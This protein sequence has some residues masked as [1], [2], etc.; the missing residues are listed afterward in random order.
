[1]KNKILTL[2]TTICLLALLLTSCASSA[3]TATSWGGAAVTDSA[4][5]YAD[6]TQVY[7]LKIDNGNTIWG[8]YPEKAVATR[9]FL[10]APVVIG[11]QVLFGDYSGLLTSLNTS[12]GKENWQFS[13]ATG[14]YIDSPLVVG[15]TIVAPNAD[16]NLYALDLNGN[17]LWTFSSEHSFWA[18][19][20]SDGETVFAPCMDHYLYAIDL[21]TGAEKWKVD[22]KA[23]LVGRVTLADGI[24]YLGSLDSDVFAVKSENGSILWEQKV[25]GGVWSAPTLVDDQLFFGDQAGNIN[26]LNVSNGSIAQTIATESAILGSGAILTEGIAF[27]N[28]NGDLILIGLDG[29]KKWTRSINGSIYSN[30][31]LYGNTLVVL[32]NKGEKPL[33][34]FDTDGNEN[35]YFTTK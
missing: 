26:I 3:S 32:A 14:K 29:E 10:A 15:D 21:A 27:G 7:A 19:P 2:I 13:D 11:D 34:A 12:D 35:W 1:M 25:A 6:G 24:L 5:Y 23:S 8:P 16:N 28:E 33:V 20:T 9:L 17:L 4:V 31:S 22:L 30:L 18:Q